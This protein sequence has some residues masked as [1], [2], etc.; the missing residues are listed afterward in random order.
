M[1]IL[2]KLVS[3]SDLSVLYLLSS[4]NSNIYNLMELIKFRLESQMSSQ[5][6]RTQYKSITC[7]WKC[8]EPEVFGIF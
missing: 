3:N 8:L 2:P 5:K 6:S 7:Y 4:L 1:N